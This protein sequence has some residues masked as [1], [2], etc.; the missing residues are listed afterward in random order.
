MT[1]TSTT[2]DRAAEFFDRYARD[3]NA[4]Y[5]NENTLFNTVV[6]HL[7]RQA[8]RIRFE[9]TIDGCRPVK[10]KTV[11]DVGAG[12][13]HYSVLLAQQGAK[14]VLGVD[15]ADGML[16]VAKGNAIKG[17]V[18]DRCEFVRGDF[19]T[20]EFD[21]KYD[22]TILMGFMDYIKHPEDVISRVAKVTKEKAFFS[23]PTDDGLL[24]IQR[25][26][27]YKSRCELY[28]Y[29]ESQVRRQFANVTNK[30]LT[31]ARSDRELFVTLD[32]R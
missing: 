26:I 23:F 5:G 21:E 8:M 11:L 32:M 4:I 2:H 31:I 27:R 19:L 9:R 6:N 3:F 28:L 18:D 13:G 20:H 22:F 25:R 12:P 24:A 15:F 17:G 30:P 7:F 29:N 14:H 16:D 10:G 1:A